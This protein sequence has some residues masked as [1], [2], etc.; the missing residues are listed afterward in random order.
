MSQIIDK[1]VWIDLETTGLI[2]KKDKIIQI[3]VLITDT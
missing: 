1:L 3:A 2:I